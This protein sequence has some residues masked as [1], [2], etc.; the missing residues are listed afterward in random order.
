M[1]NQPL[2]VQ[3]IKRHAYLAG[4]TL[5]TSEYNQT[6][7]ITPGEV[8]TGF[9]MTII[10]HILPDRRVILQY[11]VTLSALASMEEIDREQ[12]YV[13]LPQVSTRSFAQRSKM[14]M[15]QTLVLAGFEQSTQNLGNSLGVLN[16]SRDADF[17]KTLLVVTIELE[18][19][20]NV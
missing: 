3:A 19:A 10:P 9:A 4:M 5:A 18:S 16:T 1:S 8:T 12:V 7:E 15:G 14:K 11:T 13:Q 6:S 20:E 17:S 2:P